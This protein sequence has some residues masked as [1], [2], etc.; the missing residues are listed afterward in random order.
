VT[1]GGEYELSQAGTGDMAR[2]TFVTLASPPSDTISTAQS[3]IA[4]GC[5]NQ[6]D[7]LVEGAS[8]D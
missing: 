7:V 1:S 8:I 3:L 6:L 5:N 2:V 4:N